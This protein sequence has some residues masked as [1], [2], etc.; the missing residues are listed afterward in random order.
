MILHLF[1]YSS[2]TFFN[3]SLFQWNLFNFS[4]TFILS[5]C[6][7]NFFVHVFVKFCLI[8]VQYMKYLQ[9]KTLSI[10]RKSFLRL[11]G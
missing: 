6:L 11:T 2:K 9:I 4:I 3:Q 10:C 1:I 8:L 5:E 7:A